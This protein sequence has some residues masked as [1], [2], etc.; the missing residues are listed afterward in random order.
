MVLLCLHVYVHTCMQMGTATRAFALQHML[1]DVRAILQP[2][3]LVSV[4]SSLELSTSVPV[5]VHALN[6]LL[7]IIAFAH[8][9][10]CM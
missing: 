8:R 2:Q 4:V 9:H 10:A 6:L 1:L 5:K 7:V 3:I